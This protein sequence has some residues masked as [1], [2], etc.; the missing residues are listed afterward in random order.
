MQ[1]NTRAKTSFRADIQGLRALAVVSVVLDHLFHWPS[2]GFVGVDIFFVISGFLITGLLIREWDRTGSISFLDFYRRRI[3]RILP[4]ALL[5]VVVTVAVAALMFAHPRFKDTAWDGFFSAAFSANWRFLSIGSDYF[6]AN[7]P[8]S[9]LR[10]YWSLAVE[11]QF[12]FVWPWLML[13]LL[14]LTRRLL[15]RPKGSLQVAA[16]AIAVLAMGSFMWA[17]AETASNPGAAYYDTLTRVWEL[18][19]GALLAFAEPKLQGIPDRLRPWIA[20][21]GLLGILGSLFVVTP[22]S[23]FPAP[24]GL[25]PVLSTAAVIGAGCGGA[26]RFLAPL[27]NPLSQYLGNISFSLYLWHFPVTIFLGTVLDADWFYYLVAATMMVVLSAYSFRLVEDPIRRSQ[28]LSSKAKPTVPNRMRRKRRIVRP[29]VGLIASLVVLVGAVGAKMAATPPVTVPSD[30]VGASVHGPAF[31][32]DGPASAKIQ[33][34]LADALKATSWP[35]FDPSLEEIMAKDPYPDGVHECG[36]PGRHPADQ[37]MWGSPT[38]TKH[39]VLVGDSI[40]MRWAT[41]LT[42]LYAQNGWNIRVMGLYGCPFNL[43]PITKS[44]ESAKQCDDRKA[45]AVQAIQDIKP[46]VVFIG[47]TQVPEQMST[48]GAPAT[49]GDWGAGMEQI[50]AKIPNAKHKVILSPPP[51]GKDVRECY[52]PVKGP[53]ACVG[54]VSQLWFD[55]SAADRKAVEAVGGGVYVD[56][57][58]LYCTPQGLCPEMAGGIPIKQDYTHMTMVYGYHIQDALAEMLKKRGLL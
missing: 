42:K 12:Y 22:T 23:G 6:Q 47:N 40:S 56:T 7:G 30:A 5:V 16:A 10:H 25:L 34:E 26:Q 33:A 45:E 58:A 21:V 17:L 11:E 18:G 38:A 4:A 20:N 54:E 55:V 43:Y 41:P 32:V 35:K 53:Q 50:L 48:T 14:V 29:V 24:S 8:V 15:K 3:K 37:C 19:I 1:A 51:F 13:G 9:P 44:P 27:T 57:R 39:A 2:G 46:D 36:N 31:P 49:P 28:W 52:N